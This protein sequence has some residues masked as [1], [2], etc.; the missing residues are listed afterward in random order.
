[1]H[2]FSVESDPLN[3]IQPLASLLLFSERTKTVPEDIKAD[4]AKAC[5]F[6]TVW[7]LVYHA[8]R[9]VN[10]G[11]YIRDAIRKKYELAETLTKT[12]AA[13]LRVKFFSNGNGHAKPPEP[14]TINNSVTKSGNPC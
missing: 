13:E 8:E 2:D 12:E 5:T 14:T 11:G 9:Q 1:M 10:P 4:V 3:K 6:A 7:Q